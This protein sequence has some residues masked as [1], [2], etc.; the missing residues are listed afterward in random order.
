DGG[1]EAQ[2]QARDAAEGE[3]DQAV[4]LHERE[5]GLARGGGHEADSPADHVHFFRSSGWLPRACSRDQCGSRRSRE[6]ALDLAARIKISQRRR[7]FRRIAFA[8][9]CCPSP[10]FACGHQPPWPPTQLFSGSC[11]QKIR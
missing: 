6:A 9:D 10:E 8:S 1:K 11:K 2:P 3:E 4:R 7:A 5:E